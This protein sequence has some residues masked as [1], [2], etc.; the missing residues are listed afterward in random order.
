MKDK[1]FIDTWGW[2][3]IYNKREPKHAEINVF[4]REFVNREE[5][6]TRLIMYL[7]KH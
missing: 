1:L 7:M 5:L 3:V 2:I 6:S 4:Y